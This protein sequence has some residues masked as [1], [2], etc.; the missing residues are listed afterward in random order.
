MKNMVVFIDGTN[1]DR[2]KQELKDMSNVARLHEACR[3]LSQGNVVQK[4]RY[5]KGVGTDVH[6]RFSGGAFGIG[7]LRGQTIKRLTI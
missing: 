3:H 1:Q 4:V 2:S 6:E 7:F 5:C